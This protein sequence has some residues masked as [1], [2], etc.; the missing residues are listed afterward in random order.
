MGLSTRRLL[1]KDAPAGRLISLLVLCTYV[2]SSAPA[3]VRLGVVL[4][5]T[6]DG[7]MKSLACISMALDDFYLKHPTYATRV[8]LRVRDSRGDL[9]AAAL[10]GKYSSIPLLVLNLPSSI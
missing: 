6:S 4:D 8:E 3:P 10:A 9:V 5:L 1:A 7:G 2:G